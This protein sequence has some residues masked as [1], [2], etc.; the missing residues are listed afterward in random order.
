MEYEPNRAPQDQEGYPIYREHI[1]CKWHVSINDFGHADLADH[2]WVNANRFSLLQRAHKAQLAYAKDGRGARFQLLTNWRIGQNDPLRPLIHQRFKTLRLDGLFGTKTDESATGKIRKLW[3]EHLEIDDSALRLL[4]R[5]LA[6]HTDSSSLDDHRQYLDPHFENRGLRRVPLNQSSFIYDEVAFQ[7]MA[8]GRVEFTRNDFREACRREDLLSESSKTHVVFGVK[9]FEHAF[10]RLEERCTSVLNLISHFDDR[11]IRDQQDWTDT[12]YPKLKSFL[13]SAAR[14]EQHLRLILD[15]HI[16]LAFAAGAVI[17]IKSG[18]AVE[19]EQRTIGRRIWHSS[20]LGSDLGSDLTWPN[21]QFDVEKLASQPGDIAVAVSL[22]HEITS[23][24]RTHINQS[25][26][27]VS[28]LLVARPSC[29]PGTQAV[30]CGRHAFELAEKLVQR[31]N[32]EQ[33]GTKSPIH[34][35]IAA[36]NGFTFFLGQRQAGLGKTTLYEFDFEGTAGG[37]YQPSLQLPL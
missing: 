35:F 31:I 1:Q 27:S 37:G 28:N 11:S 2:D 6:L 34:L 18:R 9:S 16:T 30:A 21:W 24:V 3:R 14:S 36:P 19:L 13:H 17:N 29:G 7:W 32:A 20:D 25:L 15:A 33:T 12:V 26:P 10:D 5:T 22:T 23:A 4:V 8:Q